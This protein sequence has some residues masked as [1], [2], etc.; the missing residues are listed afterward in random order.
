[1]GRDNSPRRDDR[2]C[3][4]TARQNTLDTTAAT[5]D[6]DAF[7]RSLD[8]PM[9][10][11]RRDL[12]T[13]LAQALLASPSLT[14]ERRCARAQLEPAR[15]SAQTIAMLSMAP[16]PQRRPGRQ[17]IQPARHPRIST[18]SIPSVI[19]TT[20]STAA[21]STS[22]TTS[23]H[24]CPKMWQSKSRLSA[25]PPEPPS[26]R[27]HRTTTEDL[28]SAKVQHGS[29]ATRC[30]PGSAVLLSRCRPRIAT[31]A[32]RQLRMSLA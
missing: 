8:R 19:C 16:W 22:S 18:N 4:L 12:S 27:R 20:Y 24:S 31:K 17:H 10:S 15:H 14:A 32:Q 26:R 13:E 30:I 9:G 6:R 28:V 7:L 21:P 2:P 1:V 5:F 11:L 23:S 29:P 3:N 25:S